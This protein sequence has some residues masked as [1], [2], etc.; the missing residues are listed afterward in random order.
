MSWLRRAA[1][2]AEILAAGRG[3][4]RE[5]WR[6]VILLGG[7]CI[8]SSYHGVEDGL[9]GFIDADACEVDCIDG[10]RLGA[11]RDAA[12]AALHKAP[13]KA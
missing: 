5:L 10:I 7:I 1:R 12:E 11:V 9:L 4:R 8:E 2:Q 3:R 6:P 13:A